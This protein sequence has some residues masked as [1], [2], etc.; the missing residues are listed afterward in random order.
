[1]TIAIDHAAL[2]EPA[3]AFF[4]TGLYDVD[5]TGSYPV[6]DQGLHDLTGQPADRGRFRPPT[7]RNIAVTAPYMHDGSIA[8]L[9]EVLRFYERGGRLISDGPSA[10]D[11][12]LNPNKS[13]FVPGFTLTDDERADLL[14]FLD[15][16]T[17]TTF[18]TDPTLASP[19]P[20]ETP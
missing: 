13:P 15:A 3:V 20:P 12:K 11:G 4:N 17:D 19:W 10:G 16:L 8:T 9:D 14:A 18:L 5:G 2:A 1:M 7:L 6:T